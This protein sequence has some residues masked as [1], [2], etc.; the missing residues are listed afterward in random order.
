MT[1]DFHSF[2]GGKTGQNS[3]LY[4][5]STD[6]DWEKVNANCDASINIWLNSGASPSKLVLG[7]AFYGH[8]FQLS[9]ASQHY[10]G[11]PS[12]G[13]GTNGG[14]ADYRDVSNSFE[15]FVMRIF[16]CS[17]CIDSS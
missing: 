7:L 15:I 5:A 11:A 2:D 1:Y 10:V 16:L 14:Y 12:I 9:D 4:A 17:C 3:P 8:T 6:S 13:A